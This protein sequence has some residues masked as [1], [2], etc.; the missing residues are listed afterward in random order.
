MVFSVEL[1]TRQG[2]HLCEDAEPVVRDVARRLGSEVVVIDISQD[3]ELAVEWDLR[4][5]V[6]RSERGKVLAEGRVVAWRLSL[7][8]LRERLARLSL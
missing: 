8:L 6:V 4:I 1:L 7:S 3:P 2:C 5:P